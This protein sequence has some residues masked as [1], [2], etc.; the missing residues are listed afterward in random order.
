[1]VSYF[2]FK[3]HLLFL[4]KC[5]SRTR[6]KFGERSFRFSALAAWNELPTDLHYRL[7]TNKELSKKRLKTV[8][9]DGAYC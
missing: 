3:H 6:T 7:I 1:M 2:I 5:Y 9:F 8:L 4:C